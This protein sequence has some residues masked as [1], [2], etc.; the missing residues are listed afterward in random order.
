MASWNELREDVSSLAN[1]AIKKTEELADSASLR[2]KV[3]VTETKLKGAYEK[4]GRLTYKQLR[5]GIS[6]AEKISEAIAT[7]DS[8]R[9]EL[10]SYKVRLEKTNKEESDV[11]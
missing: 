6:Q 2:I 10:T 4:L 1:K 3:K 8:L 11:E 5:S 9:D 7:I